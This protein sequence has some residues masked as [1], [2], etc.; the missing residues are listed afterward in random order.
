MPPRYKLPDLTAAS[1]DLPELTP[2]SS[3]LPATLR[4]INLL[5][6]A[7]RSSLTSTRRILSRF[8]TDPAPSGDPDR[9]Y[10]EIERILKSYRGGLII[11]ESF[12]FSLPRNR[13]ETRI[14]CW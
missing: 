4:A 2:N 11:V 9:A 12:F 1:A 10:V 7:E 14:H 5:G 3:Q 13:Q 8:V 6:K